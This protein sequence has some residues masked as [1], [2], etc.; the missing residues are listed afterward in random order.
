MSEDAIP[1]PLAPFRVVVYGG[2]DYA[3]RDCVFRWLDRLFAPRYPSDVEGRAGTWLPRPDLEL[4]FGGAS[5]A[6]QHALDWAIVNWVKHRVYEAKWKESGKAAGVLRNQR[7]L[8]EGKPHMG[9][10]FPGGRG[11]ADMTA[12]LRKARIPVLE[13]I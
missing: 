2:R 1:Y 3:D 9:V 11:T 13:V 4:I 5:G 6:D 10:A 7:M 8:D 12:R